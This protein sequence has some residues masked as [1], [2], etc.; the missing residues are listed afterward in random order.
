MI[1]FSCVAADP[2]MRLYNAVVKEI[3]KAFG[4]PVEEGKSKV[5]CF[6]CKGSSLIRLVQ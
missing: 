1:A 3:R 4:M 2:T 5:S 6:L